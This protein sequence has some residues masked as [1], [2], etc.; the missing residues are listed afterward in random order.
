MTY[1]GYEKTKDS[2][3][4][5]LNYLLVMEHCN[6]GDLHRYLQL[7]GGYLDEREARMILL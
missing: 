2:K 4:Q 5:K 6:G 3:G 1:Y 7:R